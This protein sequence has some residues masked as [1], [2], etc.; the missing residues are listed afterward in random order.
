MLIAFNNLKQ[1]SEKTNKLSA[2]LI[3]RKKVE[4][5]SCIAA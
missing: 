2:V 5:I 1:I 4:I 3:K